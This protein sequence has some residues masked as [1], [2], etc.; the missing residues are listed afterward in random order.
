MPLYPP[1][2][3]GA[4]THDTFLVGHLGLE[5]AY[6][7]RVASMVSVKALTPAFL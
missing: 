5:A 6:T 1:E 7:G 2:A 4:H 3:L